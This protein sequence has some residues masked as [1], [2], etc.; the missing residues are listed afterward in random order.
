MSSYDP[1]FVTLC[2][3]LILKIRVASR[4]SR[5]MSTFL[6]A[7]L[8]KNAFRD[9]ASPFSRFFACLADSI[10]GCAFLCF[11]WTNGAESNLILA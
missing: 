4:H 3:R 6:G 9:S 7:L 11:G 8:F 1:F 2:G 10:S 5:F